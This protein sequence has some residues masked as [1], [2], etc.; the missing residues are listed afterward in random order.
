VRR[1]LFRGVMTYPILRTMMAAGMPLQAPV[2]PEQVLGA[3]LLTGSVRTI[4]QES[5]A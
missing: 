5:L 2:V 1:D 4:C 3:M